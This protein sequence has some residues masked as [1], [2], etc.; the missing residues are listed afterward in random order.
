LPEINKPE[1]VKK[2]YNTLDNNLT[3]PERP[4]QIAASQTILRYTVGEIH[5]IEALPEADRVEFQSLRK[6][7]VD[8]TAQEV[9]KQC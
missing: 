3:A 8:I 7:V 4:V 1:L 5:H 9:S 2:A 6:T